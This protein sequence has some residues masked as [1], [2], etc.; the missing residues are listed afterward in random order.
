[1]WKKYISSG[2]YWCKWEVE[3]MLKSKDFVSRL[4]Y[5]LNICLKVLDLHVRKRRSFRIMLNNQNTYSFKA[6]AYSWRYKNWWIVSCY[7]KIWEQQKWK[8][9]YLPNIINYNVAVSLRS[10]KSVIAQAP[11]LT[12]SL[13]TQNC[14]TYYYRLC[15]LCTCDNST[16]DSV[17][18]QL[19]LLSCLLL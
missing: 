17:I 15:M 9:L 19:E 13:F 4:S 3:A 12:H 8:K 2:K 7:V 6:Y 11:F 18:V 10:V 5:W 16:D 14:R 1:M